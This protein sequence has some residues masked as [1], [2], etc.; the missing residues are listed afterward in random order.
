MVAE[1]AQGPA[2][3]AQIEPERFAAMPEVDHVIGNNEKMHAE[4]FQRIARQDLERIQVADIMSLRE[5]A[6]QM[7]D[8]FDH[9]TRAFLQVQQG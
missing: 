8:G 5:T 2:S 3:A 1:K 9:H 4:T 6:P 7:V